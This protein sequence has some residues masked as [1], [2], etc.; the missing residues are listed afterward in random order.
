MLIIVANL[1]KIFANRE[2]KADL[3]LYDPGSAVLKPKNKMV[4]AV[5]I[6]PTSKGC[7]Q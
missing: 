4:E 1:L 3:G 2:R 5:G 7:D 6:E